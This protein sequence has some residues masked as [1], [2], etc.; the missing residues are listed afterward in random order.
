MSL[1]LI[2][3]EIPGATEEELEAAAYRAIACLFNYEGLTWHTSYWDKDA[4]RLYCVY[5]GQSVQQI[6]DHARRARIPCD[7]VKLVSQIGPEMWPNAVAQTNS[8]T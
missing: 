4:G 2:R 6:E 1:Y 5:E 3:R 8:A 7:E